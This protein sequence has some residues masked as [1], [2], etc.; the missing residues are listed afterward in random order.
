MTKREQAIKD[1]F[2]LKQRRFAV[3]RSLQRTLRGAT[4]MTGR[5]REC[6]CYIQNKVLRETRK[7]SSQFANV[8][9]KYWSD[10]CGGGYGRWI[11][12][13]KDWGELE[14]NEKYRKGTANEPGFTKSYRVPSSAIG[15]GVTKVEFKS[16]MSQIKNRTRLGESDSIRDIAKSCG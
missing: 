1:R 15:S 11:S 4:E 9:A 10:K 13:L 5:D 3:T 16:R 2:W 12:K 14:V 7:D 6:C 8:G